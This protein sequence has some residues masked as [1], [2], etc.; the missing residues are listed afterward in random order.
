M[1]AHTFV[2][3]ADL[4]GAYDEVS[5]DAAFH[6]EAWTDETREEL[7]RRAVDALRAAG[8]RVKA[9]YA[10]TIGTDEAAARALSNVLYPEGK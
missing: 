6:L 1:N 5:I 8:I 10:P 9:G 4:D 7:F 2:S 3:S